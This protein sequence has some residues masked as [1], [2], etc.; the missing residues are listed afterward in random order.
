MASKGRRKAAQSAAPHEDG[1]PARG[2]KKAAK[3]SLPP[4][5]KVALLALVTVTLL[6]YIPAL[7]APF[8][9]DDVPAIVD[10]ASIRRLVPPNSAFSPP[11]DLAVSGRPVV[12]LT[13]G[14]NYAI[15][16]LLGVDQRRDPDGPS[17][18]I[19]YRLMNVIFHLCTGA[20][21]FGI[22]RRAMRE[23][24]IPDEWRAIADPLAGAVC[25]V[26]LLHP[27]QSEAI[28]YVVQ[29]TEL[30]AS[31]F[32]V[33]TLYASLRAWEA[34]SASSRT[35][36]YVAGVLA[37]MLAMLSKETGITIA[38]IVIFYD[39]VFKFPDWRTV[40]RPGNSRSWFYLGL[41]AVCVGTYALFAAGARGD[42][43]GFGTGMAWYGYLYTQCWAIAHYLRLMFWPAGQSVDYGTELI[44]GFGGVPGL[45]LLVVLGMVTLVSVARVRTLGWLAFIGAWFFVL[46]SPSSSVVP[47]PTEVAAER[48]MYLPSVA[49]VAAVVV[50]AEWLRRRYFASISARRFVT[51]FFGIAAILAIATG[52][53]SY[54]YANP[55]LLWRGVVRHVPGNPRGYTNL[56]SALLRESPPN[57]SAADSMFRRAMA[58][59]T[60]CHFGCA[61]LAKLLAAR[62]DTAE[63]EQLF[64]R[65][66]HFDPGNA[67]VERRYALFLM[68]RGSFDRAVPHLQR[69][70]S[71]FPTPE[72]LVVLAAAEVGTGALRAGLSTLQIAVQRYPTNRNISSLLIVLRANGG[73]PGAASAMRQLALNQAGGWQ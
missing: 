54:E 60:T 48:R 8:V 36:W 22:L 44:K 71:E 24:T 28:N 66:L 56:G 63:A 53:R 72:H 9:M 29:R 1:S 7:S 20:L 16:D 47:I 19:G 6:A 33:A 55:E 46:L 59:D 64:E 18:T 17:K 68:Q 21:L 49:V 25:A 35:R 62:G 57:V 70:A 41:I 31:L 43:A 13:L 5:S 45:A 40:L 52:M 23:S 14:F 15:N 11:P 67:P 2:P 69:V 34:H 38:V 10:N 12:N 3:M 61:P 42:T 27:I 26:W 65:T 50:A 4:V 51:S 37:A 32:Y 73:D 58:I 39:R 30:L